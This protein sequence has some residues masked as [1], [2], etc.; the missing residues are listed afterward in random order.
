[1]TSELPFPP[2]EMRENVGPTQT[3][4]FDNP[5]GEPIFPDLPAE[6]Y[7]SILDFGCGCGRLARQLIQQ[8]P[9]PA[10]YLGIDLHAGM[11]EWCQANLAPHASGFEFRHHD[12]FY[13][14][15][16][17]GEGK[18]ATAPFPSG[19]GSRTLV[20]AHSVFTHLIQAH[21]EYYLSEVA[22]VLADDGVFEATWFLFDKRGMPMMQEFQNALY[23]NDVDPTNAVIFDRAWLVETAG[24]NG[25]AIASVLPPKARGFHWRVRMK[26][27]ETG[28]TVADFPEDAA[29]VSSE[30]IRAAVAPGLAG[31]Q[32]ETA[33]TS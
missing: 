9:R 15:W 27:G 10:S 23:I 5:Y 33:Q 2:L 14:A 18:P 11:I 22:R 19:D 30:G 24:K 16:N 1:M 26:P 17:P 32:A 28:F 21:A 31:D 6:A 4:A 20:I 7:R 25:L 8:Q 13:E 3:A 12:V 29:P